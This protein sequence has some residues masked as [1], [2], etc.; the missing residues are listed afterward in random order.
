MARNGR[1]RDGGGDPP[2][3]V[4]LLIDYENLQVSLKRHFNLTTPKMSLIIQE[5]QELGRLVL[6]RA[7]APWTSLDLSIDAENLYRQGIDLIYTPSGKNS[8]D[9]RMAVDA[10]DLTNRAENIGT[11]IFVTGDGD[12][13]HPLN[14]LRQQGYR[15]VVI[16]VDAAMSRMLS[17]AADAVLIY[18]RDLDPS[19]RRRVR[20]SQRQH[21]AQTSG[22][23]APQQLVEPEPEPRLMPINSAP[24]VEEAFKMLQDVLQRHG[25]EPLLYQEIGHWLGREHN[26]KSRDWYG[27]PFSVFMD[28][29]KDAGF[30]NLT[31]SG[32]NSYASLPSTNADDQVE[33][34][35][36]EGDEEETEMGSAVRLESLQPEERQA[37]FDALDEL[38]ENPRLKYFTFRT[39]LNKLLSESVLPRLNETQIRSLLNDL[40]NREPPILVRS[41]KRGRNPAG[42][43]YTFSSFALT[44][45]RDLLSVHMPGYYDE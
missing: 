30:V 36:G 13:I 4:A 17:S 15:V 3:D 24:P 14:Y 28:A 35:D 40:A 7:Y 22:S 18:E 37:L 11:I 8:A 5:A 43:T 42:G 32:G 6:A 1:G 34:D 41:M 33:D 27:V 16:G 10:V 44:K 20:A 12:L 31:T 45:D 23:Q 9:V 19:V 25:D 21:G 39:I 29:A 26:M 2:V 38:E